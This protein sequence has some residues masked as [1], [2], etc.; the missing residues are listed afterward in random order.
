VKR[1]LPR[2]LALAAL[3]CISLGA[4]QT[5]APT[6]PAVATSGRPT[7]ACTGQRI[8]DIVVFA[9]APTVASLQ[10]V[11]VLARFAR[12]LHATTRPTLIRR[13]LLLD[14]GD[15]CTELRRAESARIL[16]AQPFIADAD[17]FVVANDHGGVDLEVRT[18][19]EA[20]IVLGAGVRTRS[21]NIPFLLFGNANVGGQGVYASAAWR[22]GDGLRDAVAARVIDHQF[23]GHPWVFGV[24]AERASLG[25]SWRVEG[26]QPFLTDLQRL[27]WRVRSG[28]S[29]RYVEL[30]QTNGDVP[31]VRLARNYFDVGGIVRVGPPGR[32]SLFGASITGD[33]ERPGDRL[34]LPDNGVLIDLGP[35][36]IAYTARR[37]RRANVLY[38]IRDIS[39]VRREGLDALTA[40]QDVPLGFQL[41]TQFGRSLTLLGSNEDD[42]F[43]AGDLYIGAASGIAM[44]R[45]Q[46]QGEARRGAGSSQW[47]G[48][49]TTGRVTHYLKF[50][51]WHLNQVILEWSG[52][53]RPRIPFQLL[54]GTPEVGVRGYEKSGLAGGQRLVAKFEERF[55]LGR[56]F[57]L[58]DTGIAFFADAGR[59]W[60]GDVPF[61]TTTGVKSSIGFSILAS[62]PPRSARLWR[63]DVAFPL[64]KGANAAWT[65][66]F[67]NADR[68]QFVF[69]EARDVAESREVTV[70][71][72]IFAW[73]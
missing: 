38:G 21:P 35:S 39:F 18:S 66:G 12:T 69:R 10:R 34:I 9:E 22:T 2:A 1:T 41:G 52:D 58:A 7:V 5:G 70:P 30:R 53:Y 67:T 50:S 31:T 61:G 45:V 62:A 64:S 14:E 19:D 29:N 54:L 32:L 17:V 36:P 56:L 6:R 37:M 8:D 48:V 60:A 68:T 55:V 49:L 3:P 44:L 59:Q 11:P 63:M 51:P 42:I 28:M 27:A 40:M 72:S 47:D 15:P 4:Q 24:E 71:S 16:R 65:I 23:L 43:A 33:D 25:G 20:A 26:T 57:D 73:P 13:F 46:A